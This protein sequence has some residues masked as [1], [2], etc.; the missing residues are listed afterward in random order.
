MGEKDTIKTFNSF[1]LSSQSFGFLSHLKANESDNITSLTIDCNRSLRLHHI[2]QVGR[3]NADKCKVEQFCRSYLV[4]G[5]PAW[6]GHQPMWFLAI[7]EFFLRKSELLKTPKSKRRRRKNRSWCRISNIY[8]KC[9]SGWPVWNVHWPV[10][11]YVISLLHFCTR[12]RPPKTYRSRKIADLH[13]AVSDCFSL[14]EYFLSANSRSSEKFESLGF[15][16]PPLHCTFGLG[17]RLQFI[18]TDICTFKSMQTHSH[19]VLGRKEQARINPKMLQ[20]ITTW[21]RSEKC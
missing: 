20:T 18:P 5:C 16:V 13:S 21:D 17:V 14:L 15:L 9:G 7:H 19:S 12:G 8:I 4:S 3:G 11:C 6:N 2:M 1:R 10:W